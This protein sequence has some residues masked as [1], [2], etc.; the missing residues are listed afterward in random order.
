VYNNSNHINVI[1]FTYFTQETQQA[2]KA[3]QT[4]HVPTDAGR[5][6]NKHDKP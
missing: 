3:T 5:H 4:A 2:I 6:Y 1:S